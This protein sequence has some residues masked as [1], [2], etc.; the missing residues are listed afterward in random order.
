MFISCFGTRVPSY[1]VEISA[2]LLLKV[3]DLPVSAGKS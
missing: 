3:Y 1:E 2:A